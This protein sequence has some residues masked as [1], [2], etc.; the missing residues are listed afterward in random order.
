MNEY[1]FYNKWRMVVPIERDEEFMDDLNKLRFYLWGYKVK[2]K[3]IKGQEE[4]P[5]QTEQ[6]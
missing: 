6:P 2:I 5:N 3:K 1:E 4:Q